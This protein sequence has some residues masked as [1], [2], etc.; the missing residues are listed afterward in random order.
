MKSPKAGADDDD[1]EIFE[2]HCKERRSL[3]AIVFI[4]I[5]VITFI[6]I[7]GSE[8]CHLLLGGVLIGVAIIA[9]FLFFYVCE[10]F[11]IDD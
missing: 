9:L 10:G 8:I 3:D 5:S 6:I 2:E 1:H 11:H 7:V 4:L